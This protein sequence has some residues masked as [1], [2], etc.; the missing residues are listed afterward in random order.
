MIV[1]LAKSYL[2]CKVSVSASPESCQP[3]E[4]PQE[5]QFL[6]DNIYAEVEQGKW[7]VV[8]L[9]PSPTALP[10]T[11]PEHSASEPGKEK[12]QKVSIA[13]TTN[14]LPLSPSS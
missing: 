8:E 4:L 9:E 12:K 2:T 10:A 11:E 13:E 5:E 1:F 7:T 14:Q 3:A 6:A